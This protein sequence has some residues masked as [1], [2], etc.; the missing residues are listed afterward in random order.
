MVQVE[1]VQINGCE[2]T[3]STIQPPNIRTDPTTEEATFNLGS[4]ELSKGITL[5]EWLEMADNL[6]V[7]LCWNRTKFS[8]ARMALWSWASLV[9]ARIVLSKKE[10]THEIIVEDSEELYLV[11]RRK[12][13]GI[14]DF[15][16]LSSVLQ[17][18]YIGGCDNSHFHKKIARRRHMHSAHS[19]Y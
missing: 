4:K 18:T 5:S 13:A 16:P 8:I 7:E 15:E 19:P 17:F 2:D 14:Y 6:E 1:M 9:L 3:R 11:Q 10:K 12:G